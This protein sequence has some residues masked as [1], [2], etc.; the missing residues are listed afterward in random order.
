MFSSERRLCTSVRR[1][2]RLTVRAR[3]ITYGMALS[4]AKLYIY[5]LPEVKD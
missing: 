2:Y 3:C 4:F 1:G 5:T